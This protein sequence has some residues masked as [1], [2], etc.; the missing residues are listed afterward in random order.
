MFQCIHYRHMLEK[1]YLHK[2]LI[3]NNVVQFNTLH[4][5][6]NTKG[7]RVRFPMVC[8]SCIVYAVI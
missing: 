3:V 8:M 7:E 6:L 4:E 2:Q 5:K 1:A